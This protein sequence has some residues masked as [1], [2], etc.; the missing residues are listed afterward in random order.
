[1]DAGERAFLWGA[2]AAVFFAFI[3]NTLN[4]IIVALIFGAK[5]GEAFSAVISAPFV[6]ECAK[7]F[8]LFLLFFWKKD[9]FDGI[10]DGVVYASMVGLGFAMTENIQYY[11]KEL[12]EG[13]SAVPPLYSCCGAS[14]RRSRIRSSPA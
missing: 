13:E 2:T 7:A 3:F 11:G 10:V 14:S 6:E 8:V 4:G 1:M 5:A 9:E 12:L